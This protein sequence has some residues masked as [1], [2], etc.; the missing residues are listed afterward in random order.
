MKTRNPTDGYFGSEFPA[1]CNHCGIMAAWNRK[2][3]NFFQKFL[4]FLEKRPLIGKFSKYCSE[5]FHRDIDRRA[6]FKFHEIWSTGNRWNRALLPGQKFLPGS[7][8]VAIVRIAP[9]ICQGQPP[10]MYSECS[11]FHLNRLTFG[12]VIIAERVNTAKMRRKVNPIFGW[13]LSSSRIKKIGHAVSTAN[14]TLITTASLWQPQ[15][16]E[17]ELQM[18]PETNLSY[19]K[20][21][22]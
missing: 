12:G 13:S 2:T 1:I 11:R 17:R 19:N 20:N 7:P 3:L 10:T 16:N 9:Q 6:M 4:H 22:R 18:E 14:G 15:R 8:V 21:E 5:S